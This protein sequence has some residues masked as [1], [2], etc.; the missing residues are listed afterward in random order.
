MPS[1]RYKA[2]RAM[3]RVIGVQ[4]MLRK[5]GKDFHEML[6]SYIPKQ[7]NI[8]IPV[9]KMQKNY[10]FEK[11]I[12]D[13]TDCYRTKRKGTTPQ[14]A[15]L[16]LFG[17]GYFLPCDPGD[18]TFCG[19]FADATGRDVWFPLYPLAPRYK[20]INSVKSVLA[21]YCEMLK[22]YAPEDICL[23]GTSSGGSLVLSFLMYMRKH[24]PEIP[25]PAHLVL[26]SP[27]LQVPPSDKQYMQMKT[28]EDK[29]AMIPPQFFYEIAPLLADEKDAYLLSPM[30]NDLTG[31]PPIDI[32]YGSWEVM[33]AYLPDM[34][35]HC[36][37]CGVNLTPHVGKEM[38][39][40]WLAMDM[41]PEGKEAR[42]NVFQI[43]NRI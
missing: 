25:L 16:Y 1:I 34:I 37:S 40:C 3:F 36:D 10:D 5:S 42:Q 19:Q 30:L 39:H 27:G 7:D 41:T 4:K 38:M 22:I 35:A 24:E 43:V 20:L 32:I 23:F 12:V 2:I 11:S 17:G 33:Y 21:V 18:F 13:G 14:K 6:V 31:F 8:K 26:Q 15:L 29:D 28:I 9:N